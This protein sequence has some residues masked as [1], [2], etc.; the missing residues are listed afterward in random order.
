MV[1]ILLLVALSGAPTCKDSPLFELGRNKNTNVVEYS[2][3]VLANGSIDP[4]TPFEAYWLMKAKDG[5]REP[6]N[7]LERK[8][9]YG[10][11]ASAGR[12]GSLYA[13]SLVAFPDRSLQVLARG[14]G[15]QAVTVIN[16]V[17]S[18]LVR[19]FVT[20]KEELGDPK[21]QYVDLFGES[22]RDGSS[23]QE[24]LYPKKAKP[25]HQAGDSE[26]F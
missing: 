1:S 10:F 15:F 11:T 3:C 5:R 25:R 7:E 13:L 23:T 4:K 22:V 12:A 20:A 14:D 8:L 6:L 24:R 9:A 26:A 19:V 21:V 17:P 18:R 16:G 2:A